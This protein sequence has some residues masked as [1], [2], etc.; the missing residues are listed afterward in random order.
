MKRETFERRVRKETLYIG[1]V[2]VIFYRCPKK[3]IWMLRCVGQRPR[4]A[5]KRVMRK[6][7]E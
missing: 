4:V 6:D 2:P 1:R 3:R 5:Q 7:G